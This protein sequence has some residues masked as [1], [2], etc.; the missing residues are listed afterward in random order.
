MIQTDQPHLPIVA[1]SDMGK[2]RKNNEDRFAVSAYRLSK[3]NPTPALLA[4]LSDGIGGH[5]AGE[6]A[7]EL[8]VNII[9]Q[10]VA[11]SDGSDPLPTIKTAIETASNEI[12]RQSQGDPER[13][14][15]GGTCAMVW[16]IG[17]KLYMSNIGDSRIFLM[18]NGTIQQISTDHTW[19]QEALEIGLITP[20]QVAGH[21]NAHVIRRY[22]GSPQPPQVD[23]RIH[24]APKET[25]AQAL[26]NQGMLL[27]KDDKLLLC[28]DGLTDLVTPAEILDVFQHM[29][30]LQTTVQTLIDMANE[31]GGHDNITII[32]VAVPKAPPAAAKP[33]PVR[34]VIWGCLGALILAVLAGLA[35]AGF[36][37]YTG[38]I[39]IP[40]LPSMKPTPT[41]TQ[42]IAPTHTAIPVTET[43][44]PTITP[45]ITPSPTHTVTSTVTQT[46]GPTFTPWPTTTSTPAQTQPVVQAQPTSTNGSLLPTLP[47]IPKP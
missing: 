9:T 27:Q 6:V 11:E 2:N 38:V 39:K 13:Q 1:Q 4:V 30:N 12:Y 33:F 25:D 16:I 31:R 26:A 37:W 14:G 45:T 34:Y 5:R 21:P 40:F 41:L 18:R 15:M 24:L 36:L 19:I 35:V 22:L 10:K 3:K 44:R 46:T 42:T 23:F 28:S 47:T 32:S 7:A 43:P 20:D 29:P 8:A 17:H